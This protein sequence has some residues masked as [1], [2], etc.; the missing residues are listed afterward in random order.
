[1][2]IKSIKAAES[3]KIEFWGLSREVATYNNQNFPLA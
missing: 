2:K 1:M 3:D